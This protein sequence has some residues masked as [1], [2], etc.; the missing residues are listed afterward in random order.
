MATM[1]QRRRRFNTV[2][3]TVVTLRL[4][5]STLEMLRS[6]PYSDVIRALRRCLNTPTK[7]R[8]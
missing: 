7:D 1:R 3:T 4:P 5:A 2:E 8:P 6:I